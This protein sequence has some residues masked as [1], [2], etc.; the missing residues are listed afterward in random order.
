MLYFRTLI[1]LFFF[2]IQFVSISF[3]IDADELGDF[4]SRSVIM[5]KIYEN[6]S[7]TKEQD[8]LLESKKLTK[9]PACL[10]K[11]IKKGNIENVNLLLKAKVN[12]N[13]S[14][15]GDYPIYYAAKRNE[16]EIVKLLYEYGAK[17]DR[18]FYSELYEAVKHEN[19]ELA[20]FLINRG[21]KV[22]Y[23]DSLTN[24]T[25]L[26][27]ALKKDMILTASYLIKKG[28]K[29]DTKTLK[30]LK[31]KKFRFQFDQQVIKQ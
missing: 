3:A 28:A 20:Q 5:R 17:L 21:A 14:Y 22:N 30:L 4:S 16:T 1:L 10:F 8:N 13:E 27:L 29:A 25:I 11:Q 24:N 12:P 26:Y 6:P 7:A 19:F 15:Y 18:G 23:M 31:K 9:T 2:C